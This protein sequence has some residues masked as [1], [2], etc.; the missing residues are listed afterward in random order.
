MLDLNTDMQPDGF[1]KDYLS[2]RSYFQKTVQ[3]LSPSL[4]VEVLEFEHPLTGP[5][6]EP[7]FCD[8]VLL[9]QSA[10]P[11]KVLVIISGTHGVEGLSGSAVQ[12]DLLPELASVLQQNADLGIVMIHALNPWGVAWLR[13]CDHEGIDLNRNFIDF[14]APLPEL[15]G[16]AQIK[17]ACSVLN[18]QGYAGLKAGFP[19]DAFE[20]FIATLTKGQYQDASGLFYGGTGPSWSNKLLTKV[21]QHAF[22][23]SFERLSVIDVHTGLGPYGYGEVINDHEPNTKGFEWAYKLYGDNAYSAL[24]GESTSAPKLGLLDYF[25]HELMQDRGCFI[26]LEFGTYPVE[27]LISNLWF[28]QQYQASLTEGEIRSLEADR[29]AAMKNFF[30]PFELSWQQQVLFRARQVVN[31]ALVG[32]TQDA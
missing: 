27:Q 25:W 2:S 11:N 8:V 6:N 9:G 13:R 3:S 32:M 24:L 4:L 29:V 1:Q 31:L 14:S 26:T 23:Q 7:L 20:D 17:Q 12:S 5:N 15:E 10:K 21:T 16:Y 30:Y 18:E 22:F 28:E 19:A